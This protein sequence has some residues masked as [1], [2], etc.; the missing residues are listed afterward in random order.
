MINKF[1]ITECDINDIR[2]D[3][4][5]FLSHIFLLHILTVSIDKKEEF[6]NKE[7]LKT[8]LLTALA[9]ILYHI[10]LKKL[11]IPIKK[12]KNACNISKEKL[13]PEISE[14]IND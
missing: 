6:L 14:Y 13:I 10:F 3:T 11:S 9:I 12:L 2:A 5:R 8:M 1:D 7:V 4:I